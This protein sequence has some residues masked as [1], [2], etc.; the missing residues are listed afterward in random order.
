M[1]LPMRWIS[2]MWR[3]AFP[4]SA[5][6]A[7]LVALP[8]TV[9][10]GEIVSLDAALERIAPEAVVHEK[11]TLVLSKEKA[12]AVRRQA[13][14]LSS[15]LVSRYRLY[16]RQ[17]KLL[18]TAYIDTHLV[19]SLAETLLIAVDPAGRVRSVEVLAFKEPPEYRPRP[20]WYAQFNGRELGDELRIRKGIRV[21]AG[22]TL[23][24]HAATDAV[25]RCL[26]VH[27]LFPPPS[28]IDTAP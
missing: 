27:R 2:S 20:G 12:A 26:A 22:A 8:A 9:R 17:G 4:S 14:P 28:R 16:D 10:G 11:D 21:L 23:S 3:W 19:R 6:L 15:R 18:A 5:L 13:G 7:L 1:T 25:R 24:S